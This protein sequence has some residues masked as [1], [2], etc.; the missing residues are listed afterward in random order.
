MTSATSAVG[1]VFVVSIAPDNVRVG[2]R[3]AVS[4]SVDETTT[5]SG[6]RLVRVGISRLN[7]DPALGMSVRRANVGS[8]CAVG[9]AA[10][11]AEIELAISTPSFRLMVGKVI[12]LSTVDVVEDSVSDCCCTAVLTAADVS[13]T[14]DT[15]VV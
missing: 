1:S 5:F 12:E 13:L 9:V 2:K 3:A 6:A 10:S 8:S 4:R 14:G 15:L 11:V 7:V